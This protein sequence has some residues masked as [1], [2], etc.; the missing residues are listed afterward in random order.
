VLGLMWAY[1]IFLGMFAHR[2][3]TFFREQ[4][5]ENAAGPATLIAVPALLLLFYYVV[6]RPMA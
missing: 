1:P 6:F 4:D 2:S 5:Y 3:W